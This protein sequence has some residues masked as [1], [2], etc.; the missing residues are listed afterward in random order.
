MLDQ[1]LSAVET[2]QHHNVYNYDRFAKGPVLR[3][4]QASK[5]KAGEPFWCFNFEGWLE[6]ID[7]VGDS[8][9]LLSE[10]THRLNFLLNCITLKRTFVEFV[11]DTLHFLD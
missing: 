7:V 8:S 1:G 10:G 3:C 9:P 4:S 11:V 2:S 5:E 6:P